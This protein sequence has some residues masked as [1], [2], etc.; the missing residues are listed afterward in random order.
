MPPRIDHAFIIPTHPKQEAE[1]QELEIPHLR[2]RALVRVDPKPELRV[3]TDQRLHHPLAR[4]LGP[5][6]R[7]LLG[8]LQPTPERT[9]TSKS[10]F[11][12]G[13]QQKGPGIPD[14]LL[15]ALCPLPYCTTFCVFFPAFLT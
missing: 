1:A 6:V 4:A 10:M 13:T 11:M 9:L 2:Q 8:S 3:E 14:P 7:G 15:Y 5:H 12:L